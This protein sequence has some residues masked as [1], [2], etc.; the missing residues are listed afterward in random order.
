MVG[1]RKPK[2]PAEREMSDLVFERDPKNPK[3]AKYLDPDGL[4]YPGRRLV[5]GD[6][7]YCF[8]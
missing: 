6:I 5:Q 4:P 8:R 1:G 7:F 3:L 2:N